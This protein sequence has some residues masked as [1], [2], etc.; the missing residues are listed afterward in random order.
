MG[1][2]NLASDIVGGKPLYPG[3]DDRKDI[4]QGDQYACTEKVKQQIQDSST[5]SVSIGGERSQKVRGNRT[6]GSSD[7]QING[8]IIAQQSLNGKGLK[9][10][11]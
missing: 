9:D 8:H 10:D 3:K 11:C 2:G 5:F 4:D 7:Y 1:I 6:D